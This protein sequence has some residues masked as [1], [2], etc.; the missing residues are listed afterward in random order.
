MTR[1]DDLFDQFPKHLTVEQLAQV[2][3]VTKNTAYKWLQAGYVPAYKVGGGPG[4]RPAWVIL[5]DEVKDHLLARRNRP[6]EEEA[7]D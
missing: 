3:G 2:L 1:V 6:G 4:G 5:R 7:P